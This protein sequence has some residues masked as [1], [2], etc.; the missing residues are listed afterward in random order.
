MK[1]K[2]AFL[3]RIEINPKKLAGKP[4]IRGTRI[5]VEQVLN[6]LAA[7]VAIEEIL[8]D[9]PQLERDDILVFSS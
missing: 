8:K 7:G 1:V 4:V 5:A 6:M 2:T 3:N 9:F